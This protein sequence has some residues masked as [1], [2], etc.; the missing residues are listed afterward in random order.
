MWPSILPCQ[1]SRCPLP[2]LPHLLPCLPQSLS[3]WLLTCVTPWSV[4]PH[5]SIPIPST[6]SGTTCN[7]RHDGS[8]AFSFF[9]GTAGFSLHVEYVSWEWRSE[10]KIPVDSWKFSSWSPITPQ[11][12]GVDLGWICTLFLPMA[13]SPL[14]PFPEYPASST[15]QA[16]WGRGS[17]FGWVPSGH[18]GNVSWLW[19]YSISFPSAQIC[20]P[21]PILSVAS[22][23]KLS[24]N[25]KLT[26]PLSSAC[27]PENCRYLLLL[28]LWISWLHL[29]QTPLPS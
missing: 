26:P 15:S 22:L 13:P 20:S 11:R 14:F 2:C 24:T 17:H 28:R 3:Q 29:L 16:P 19:D 4:F 8:V 18:L 7:W 5:F 21:T 25:H 10:R 23:S 1:L 9:P 12:G 6:E 27:Q